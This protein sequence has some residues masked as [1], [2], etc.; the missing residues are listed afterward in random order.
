LML[1]LSKAK[2]VREFVSAIGQFDATFADRLADGLRRE[3]VRLRAEEKLDGD[4]L[5]NQLYIYTSRNS[6]QI[7][8]QAAGLAVLGYFFEICEVF[9][10]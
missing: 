5:F 4:D 10:R 7:E 8:L 6:M 3:Y 2:D 1:A 9:E